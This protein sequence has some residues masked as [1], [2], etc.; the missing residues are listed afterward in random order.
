VFRNVRL[1]SLTYASVLLMRLVEIE[2]TP[3]DGAIPEN[4]ALL[5]ADA[6]QRIATLEEQSRAAIPAFVPSDFELVYRAL[7][8]IKNAN[9]ATGRR[10]LEWGS[11]IGVVTCLAV[12]L[13][14][15]AAGIEIEPKLVH[16]AEQLA[17]KHRIATQFACGSFVPRGA[18]PRVDVSGDFSWLSTGGPDGYEELQLEPDDFDIV[19][20]YPWPGEE[21][22]IFDLF[23]DCTAVGTLLL[24]YHGQEGLRLQRKTRR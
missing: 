19:F 1:E 21:Q 4:V 9:L 6:N 8:A 22:V 2:L 10:F 12:W 20:A 14:F 13:G 3:H 11:G 17:R 15:D 5:L 18:E 16:I 23:A 7:A 24:T